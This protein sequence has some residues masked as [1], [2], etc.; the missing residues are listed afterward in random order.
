M[1]MAGAEATWRAFLEQGRFMLQHSRTSGR[2]LFY[3]RVAE[4]GT[5]VDNLEWVEAS[6]N[7]VV[8]AVTVV[9]KKD[10]ADSYNV[11]LVD[12]AEGPRLMSRVDGIDNDAV[13]IGMGVEARIVQEEA[14][15]TLV[16]VPA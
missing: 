1:S 10:P 9:R 12:L 15:P 7:G 16:F 2:Y 5:G 4:P 14:G 6:G 3:P 13:H 8:H 11:V